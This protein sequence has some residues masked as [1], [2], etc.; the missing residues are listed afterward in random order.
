MPSNESEQK[1]IQEMFR[2]DPLGTLLGFI[3][4]LSCLTGVIW[5]LKTYPAEIFGFIV[6][7]SYQVITGWLHAADLI[8]VAF[9]AAFLLMSVLQKYAKKQETLDSLSNPYTI[10][11]FTFIGW[12][13]LSANHCVGITGVLHN[14][15]KG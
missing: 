12:T 2:E 1:T 11:A 4:L 7:A 14:I 8:V 3:V 10:V 6:M 15:F 9:I 5:L 13:V